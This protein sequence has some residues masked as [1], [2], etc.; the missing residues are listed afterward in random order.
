MSNCKYCRSLTSD[1]RGGHALCNRHALCWKD[2]GKLFRPSK[3]QDCIVLWQTANDQ[4]LS[5][6]S[7]FEARANF[8]QH[9]NS[10]IAIR[11]TNPEVGPREAI[12]ASDK[13][14]LKFSAAWSPLVDS[15]SVG[16]LLSKIK[17]KKRL[18]SPGSRSRLAL[19]E[20]S[21]CSNSPCSKRD[22]VASPESKVEDDLSPSPSVPVS[23][24]HVNQMSPLSTRG[25]V[26]KEVDLELNNSHL[27]S[28]AS[29]D[30]DQDQQQVPSD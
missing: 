27:L 7:R 4:S 30:S 21:S 8:T 26:S 17:T 18:R 6:A 25:R 29:Q 1:P 13:E 14:K 12:W 23:T 11:G 20:K 9:V 2:N 10:L 22:K 5:E 24:S 28:P 19:S 3:C 16:K 15:T